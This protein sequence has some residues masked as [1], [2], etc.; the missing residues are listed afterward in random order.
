MKKEEL[1]IE[2]CACRFEPQYEDVE[3]DEPPYW[4]I[5]LYVVMLVFTF[6]YAGTHHPCGYRATCSV[7]KTVSATVAA[8]FW[9]LYWS[10]EAQERFQN[11]GEKNGE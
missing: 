3:E 4:V 10:W 1:K 8:V 7:D 6:G 2:D 11:H 5:A 9:P